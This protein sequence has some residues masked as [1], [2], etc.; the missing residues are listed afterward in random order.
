MTST[1]QDWHPPAPALEP[2]AGNVI[3]VTT[4]EELFTAVQTAEPGDTIE[5]ADGHYLLPTV[6]TIGT[7]DLCLRSASGDRDAVVVDG[8]DSDHGELIGFTECHRVT[9]ADLTIQNVLHNGFKLN[10]NIGRSVGAITIHNCVIHNVWQRG[11][12]GVNGP[13]VEGDTDLPLRP[14]KRGRPSVGRH[15]VDDCIIR[16]CLFYNDRPKQIDD[17]PYERKNPQNFDGNYIAAI[18]VMSARKWQIHDNVFVGIRGR[19]GGARG[20]IF[21][22]Q[23]SEDVAIER[24][25][26]VDCDSGMWLGLSWTPEDTRR[27]VR[28]TVR[29]NQIT[30]PGRTG[31]LLS[32]HVDSRVT[33]NTILDPFVGDERP[34]GTDIDD[35][36]V[37]IPS[38]A[39]QCRPLRIGIENR[40]LLIDDNLL[41]S[42]Q[43][44]HVNQDAGCI[45]LN[46]N[47]WIQAAWPDPFIDSTKG[48]LRRTEAGF[49][50][51]TGA[52]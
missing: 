5:I 39:P 32:R 36:G 14:G 43:D 40:G 37:L 50:L 49:S 30:R 26:I 12:K 21:F 9:V 15:F 20:A 25:V 16:Y 48:D 34:S 13:E 31:I 35:G 38:Q 18:D 51:D 10:A 8:A 19:N 11:F 27:C 1:R 29:G 41:I 7:D 17:E 3:R 4:V 44:V 33:G 28:Y 22:W 47:L 42:E 52:I 46:N 2:A 6:L 24:N 45:E 23:G